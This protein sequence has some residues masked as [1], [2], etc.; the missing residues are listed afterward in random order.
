M[1]VYGTS[2]TECSK[3]AT[4]YERSQASS[5]KSL[6][7]NHSAVT[8]TKPA[9]VFYVWYSELCRRQNTSPICAIRSP[10]NKNNQVLRFLADRIKVED[11]QPIINAIGLDTSLHVISIQRRLYAQEFIANADT[12]EKVKKIKKWFGAI[13]T[14]YVMKNLG[15]ALASC[16][17]RSKVISCLELSGLHITA[18]FLRTICLALAHNTSLKFLSFHNCQLGDEGCY[19]ICTMLRTVLN[20]E[21]IDLS[22]CALSPKSGEHLAKLI[23]YQQ[24]NRY[25]QSWHSSLRYE[26]PVVNN[27][28]GLKRIC[29]NNNP[30]FGD[31][32]LDLILNELMDDLW[33][34]ALDMQRCNITE[35]MANRIVDVIQYSKSLQV[36]DFRHN[37]LSVGT[38]ERIFEILKSKQVDSEANTEYSWCYTTTSIAGETCTT[39]SS[40]IPPKVAPK[41]SRIVNNQIPLK[42]QV[43]MPAMTN[44]NKLI[45]LRRMNALKQQQEITAKLRVQ[46][47]QLQVQ[48]NVETNKR[49]VAENT[50]EKLQRQ[51]DAMTK[52][53]KVNS[54]LAEFRNMETYLR[55]LITFVKDNGDQE[56][57]QLKDQLE[58]VMDDIQM[59]TQNYHTPLDNLSPSSS[60]TEYTPES[61]GI[62]LTDKNSSKSS[63]DEVPVRDIPSEQVEENGNEETSCLLQDT[64]DASYIESVDTKSDIEMK[65]AS[66]LSAESEELLMNDPLPKVQERLN[67]NSK[68]MY[69]CLPK[70]IAACNE[71]KLENELKALTERS[72]SV[73]NDGSEIQTSDELTSVNSVSTMKEN[74]KWKVQNMFQNMS[75]DY[76][77]SDDVQSTRTGETLNDDEE[78]DNTSVFRS[79][80]ARTNTKLHTLKQMLEELLNECT[81]EDISSMKTMINEQSKSS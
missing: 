15:K 26:E 75:L 30:N 33:I 67:L 55:H 81:D 66:V 36:A 62:E 32:G 63:V 24:I 64:I 8:A 46:I 2:H 29:I 25:C 6:Q 5:S 31:V 4:V 18:E 79:S 77:G 80:S 60:F 65:T 14:Q 45:E 51:V 21:M 13:C 68:N 17:K 10:Y 72:E 54:I 16:L 37:S 56:H 53:R 74:I 78:T 20:I 41:P 23:R 19:D 71:E 7:S 57:G 27:M 11:W 3:S 52:Q 59:M 58:E 40:F 35:N 12:E 61:S 39:S 38:S 44:Q 1:S 48:L 50:C 28:A 69:E 9:D 73:D 34:K 47:K 76:A 70:S 42:R 49:K 43:T 22:G